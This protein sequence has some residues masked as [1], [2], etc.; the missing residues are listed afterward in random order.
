MQ[1][2]VN[3]LLY[4]IVFFGLAILAGALLLRLDISTVPGRGISWVN[5]LFTATSATC[6]TG[7]AVVDTGTTFSR[8]GQGVILVLIQVGGL[9]IMTLASLALYLMR[10]RVSLFDRIAVG[11]N[12]LHDAS[13][14]L[15][16]FLVSIVLL[17]LAVELTGALL[18]RLLLGDGI[19]PYSAL[20]HSVSAFCNA[21]FSLYP[22]SLSRWRDNLPVN[23]VF[24]GLIVLGGIGFSVLVESGSR[25]AGMFR[26]RRRGGTRLTW[27]TRV[28]LTTTAALIAGGALALLLSEHVGYQRPVALR[29]ALITSLFQ[30]V[31]CR[32]AG[33]NTVEI[34][35]MTDVSLLIMMFLMWVGGA[36]GS[37]AGGIKV[38]T[39]RVAAAFFR[40]RTLGRR[41]SVIGPI[42]AG[43][44]TVNRALVLVL[45]SLV[46][47]ALAVLVLL[48]TEGGDIPHSASRG[49][50]LEIAFEVVSAFGTTGLSTG[51]TPG[52]TVAGKCI[53]MVLMFIGRLGPL[54]FIAVLQEFQKEEIVFRPEGDL[55]IG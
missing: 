12:L 9:G 34:G 15:G 14:N 8:F 50:F 13:F 16:R 21:G 17:S 42:A 24:I 5:A 36:P 52:L 30:S 39:L 33:F 53:I 32:T 22:D 29:T 35:S 7:L 2:H 43:R 25:L 55:L 51:L 11:Q 40:G 4:P 3:P 45:F 26:H 20:F 54:I 31:T 44:G 6:V 37:T 38:T 23:L 28:V 19:S 48:V 46:T 27:Y 10:R 18:L 49:L 41:Q 1:R 47:I